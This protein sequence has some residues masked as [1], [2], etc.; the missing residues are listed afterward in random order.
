VG[1]IGLRPDEFRLMYVDEYTAVARAY[2][3]H[4]EQLLRDGWERTRMLASICIQPHVRKRI[5][6]KELLKFPWDDK[7]KESRLVPSR[8][9][10]MK[11]YNALME[12]IDPRLLDHGKE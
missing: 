12:R 4:Q 9:E 11:E 2:E 7:P 5:P 10:A 3:R 6:P 1:V 8:E